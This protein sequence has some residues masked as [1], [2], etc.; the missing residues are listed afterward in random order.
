MDKEPFRPTIRTQADLENAWHHL[1]SPLGFTSHSVWMMVIEPTHQPV[2]H[3][4]QIQEADFPP[5]DEE[6]R[7][8]AEFLRGLADDL[9]EPGS[10]IAFLI[11]RPGRNGAGARDRTWA[12][13]LYRSCRLA[14]VPC[15]T[16]HLATDGELLPLP[17]DDLDASMT[18]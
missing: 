7:G 15:E 5:D 13:A 9:L 6:Q 10:R 8:F 18:A 1:I 17:L 12:A 16:V 4:T 2:P 11:S 3:L 14:G